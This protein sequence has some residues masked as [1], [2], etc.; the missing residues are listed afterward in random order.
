MPDEEKIDAADRTFA[1]MW[2]LFF[3][4]EIGRRKA[5]GT[6]PEDFSLYVAQALFPPSGANRVLLNEQVRGEFLVRSPR[7]LKSGEPV[8]IDDL[9]HA[10]VY[11]LPD[12]LLDHGHFTLIRAGDGWRMI[13]NF[14]SGRAKAK[15]ML[16]LANQF[17]E[18]A[19][20]I[21]A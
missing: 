3:E 19:R 15:D 21:E 4:P 10:E 5:A 12:E 8:Y 20:F 6:L 7:E 11:E 16:E 9:Q 17:L 2:S 13:F 14:L 1:D 18:A